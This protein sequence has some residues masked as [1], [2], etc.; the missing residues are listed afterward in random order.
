MDCSA[1]ADNMKALLKKEVF[2]ASFSHSGKKAE[3][4]KGRCAAHDLCFNSYDPIRKRREKA[5]ALLKQI[6]SRN[7]GL[8]G[9][10]VP[11]KK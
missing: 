3:Q 1:Q 11:E 7:I 6:M 9:R 10:N 2:K 5:R 8:F 4:E